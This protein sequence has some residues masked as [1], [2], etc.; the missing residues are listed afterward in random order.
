MYV[1][2]RKKTI[3]IARQEKYISVYTLVSITLAMYISFFLRALLALSGVII[4]ILKNIAV[5]I[6]TWY[7]NKML[8][9]AACYHGD[10]A[11]LN[12]AI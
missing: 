7:F 9:F 10:I 11:D 4:L 2:V 3:S 12:H 8:V 6:L 5:V 1:V